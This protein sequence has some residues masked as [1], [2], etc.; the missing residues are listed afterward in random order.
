M[1]IERRT[2]LL[3]IAAAGLCPAEAAPLELGV[4]V[5]A[6]IE[7]RGQADEYALRLEQGQV[8]EIMADFTEQL[9]GVD[10]KARVELLDPLGEV[11]AESQFLGLDD[12]RDGRIEAYEVER[13]GRYTVRVRAN[14]DDDRAV[15]RYVIAADAVTAAYEN[16]ERGEPVEGRVTGGKIDSYAIDLDAG[17]PV[18]VTLVRTGRAAHRLDVKLLDP[19]GR[20]LWKKRAPEIRELD[21]LA[22]DEGRHTLVVRSP[23]GEAMPYALAIGPTD[24]APAPLTGAEPIEAEIDPFGDI[25]EYAIDLTT[26]G[27]IEAFADFTTQLADADFPVL[28]RLLSPDRRLLEEGT[29]SGLADARDHRIRNFR[30][31][32]PGTYTLQVL[33]RSIR[34]DARF[35]YTISVDGP[36]LADA[37]SATEIACNEPHEG[38]VSGG[39]PG[40]LTFEPTVGRPFAVSIAR[41][42][43]AVERLDAALVSPAGETLWEET[44]SQM[45]TLGVIAD[46]PGVYRLTLR[47]PDGERA[48]YTVA[49]ACQPEAPVTLGVGDE[50]AD[51]IDVFGD[52]DEYAIR[53]EAGQTIELVAQFAGQ[54]SGADFGVGLR[55]LDPDRREVGVGSVSG[56]DDNRGARVASFTAPSGGVYTT[57][58]YA[59]TINADARF[60]YRLSAKPGD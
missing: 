19:A 30:A 25:D 13:D 1:L 15:F 21:T 44:A 55:L 36:G 39:Q 50:A 6:A 7:R 31:P 58:V 4:P 8:V 5:E 10:F 53:L 35:G 20:E 57:Q 43:G 41:R 38:E 9:A 2:C 33:P 45:R 34:R 3:A 22:R 56:L 12:A 51:A 14:R 28:L 48:P 23:N 29:M 49:V 60:R 18:F 16:Y 40:V 46:D 47:S 42:G 27:P 11:V 59:R 26:D 54:L 52:V 32:E 17:D 24:G 37:S